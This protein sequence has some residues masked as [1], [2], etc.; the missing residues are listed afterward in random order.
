MADLSCEVIAIIIMVNFLLF[1]SLF[2]LVEFF[3]SFSFDSFNFD[4]DFNHQSSPRWGYERGY[5]NKVASILAKNKSEE[6]FSGADESGVLDGILVREYRNKKRSGGGSNQR[7]TLK[8]SNRN[9]IPF[10]ADEKYDD[11]SWSDEDF[12]SLQNYADSYEAEDDDYYDDYSDDD[13]EGDYNYEDYG[14]DEYDY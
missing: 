12:L 8:E 11:E 7:L 1:F 9:F 6:A 4:V 5:A 2:F 10:S 14:D 3:E 13:Y